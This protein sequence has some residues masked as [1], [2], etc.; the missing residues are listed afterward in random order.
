MT[1][2]TAMFHIIIRLEPTRS[3]FILNACD[4][5]LMLQLSADECSGYIIAPEFAFGKVESRSLY[6]I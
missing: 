4:D 1:I 2:A 6:T 5:Y 3:S